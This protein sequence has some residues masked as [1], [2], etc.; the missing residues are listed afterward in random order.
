MTD[1]EKLWQFVICDKH[2]EIVIVVRCSK[3]Q[4]LCFVFL[5][6]EAVCHCSVERE[7]SGLG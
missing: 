5:G 2:F 6:K 3:I 1:K 4:I 7:S